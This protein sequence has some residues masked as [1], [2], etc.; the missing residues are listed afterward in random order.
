MNKIII[1]NRTTLTDAQALEYVGRVI[2]M[3]RVSNDGKQ[4][5]YACSFPALN[6]LPAV[7]VFSGLNAKSDRFILLPFHRTE[8]A[9]EENKTPA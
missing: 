7:D 8:P 9:P 6:G 1:D 5:C 3:G 2:R 4:Y